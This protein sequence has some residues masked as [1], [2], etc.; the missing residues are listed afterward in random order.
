[1]GPGRVNWWWLYPPVMFRLGS[2]GLDR[3]LGSWKGKLAVVPSLYEVPL[4]LHRAIKG[5][6]VLEG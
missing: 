6:W 1:M 4:G 5:G 2:I 3:L